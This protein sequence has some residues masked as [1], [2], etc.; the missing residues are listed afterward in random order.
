MRVKI[1][2]ITNVADALAAAEYGADAVGFVLYPDSPRAVDRKTV[3]N[4]VAQLPPFVTTAGVF[5]NMKEREIRA[6][7]DETGLDLIQLQGDEPPDLCRRLGHR[8]V[9]AIRVRDRSSLTRM[10][11]YQVR[12]FVLD[13]YREGQLGGTGET[14][15][16]GLAVEAKRLG[17][18]ILAGGLTPENV[19]QAIEQVRP[20]GVDVSSGV[21]ERMGK[22]DPLKMKRFIEA[23][24][25][26]RGS[27]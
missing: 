23:A 2:G 19:R 8:V 20:Y 16:W 3:K 13:T 15:D 11:P 27:Q 17:K 25:Q 7:V 14:F 24:K 10:I 18:I 12:A 1:C 6:I 22:K 4:I 5:A 21:E 9:K 26:T